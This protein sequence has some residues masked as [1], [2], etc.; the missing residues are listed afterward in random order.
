MSDAL[1][2]AMGLA[3]L[4]RGTPEPS[5]R[6]ERAPTD[7]AMNA[8]T[9]E[10]PGGQTA[11]DGASLRVIHP[12][13]VARPRRTLMLAAGAIAIAGVVLFATTSS[14]APSPAPAEAR[15]EP[16]AVATSPALPAQSAQQAADATPPP[17]KEAGPPPGAAHRDDE[18]AVAVLAPKKERR[19]PV[20][21]KPSPPPASAAARPE[22]PPEPAA[23]PLSF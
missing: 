10:V 14:D 7:Q 8:T 23:D 13:V 19:D 4:E 2:A 1:R 3:P 18:R 6:R 20:A 17:A 5:V 12:P 21:A 22:A 11:G 16:T 15:V 9:A